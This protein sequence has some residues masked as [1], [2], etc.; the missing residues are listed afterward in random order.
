MVMFETNDYDVDTAT[1]QRMS[2][3]ERSQSYQAN[4]M[5]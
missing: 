1:M 3:G 4:E 2:K 5:L